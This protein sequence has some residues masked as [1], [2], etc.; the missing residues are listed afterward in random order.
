MLFALRFLADDLQ[1]FLLFFAALAVAFVVGIAFH[2]FSHALTARHLGDDTAERLGRLTLNPLRHLDPA[3]TALLLL[4]GFGW[5][6][7]V[8]VNAYRLRNGPRTG[9]AVV[10]AAGPVSNFVMAALAALPVRLGLVPLVGLA[11]QPWWTAGEYVGLFL[12]FLIFIN[13]VLGLFNL[14]PLAPLDGFKV[15]LGLLPADLA[16]SFQRLEPYGMGILMLLIGVSWLT[17]GAVDPL[18]AVISP[19]QDEIFRFL[20]QA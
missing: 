1:T 3:G 18:G 5:G 14:I 20:T 2:E 4:V 11:P 8:P 10:A 13:V 9:M 16:R 12:F 17:R 7:P 6:K 19:A 15:A